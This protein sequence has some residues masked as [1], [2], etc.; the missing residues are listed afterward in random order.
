MQSSS[1]LVRTVIVLVLGVCWPTQSLR[2]DGCIFGKGG[3]Y[4]PEKEQRAFIEWNDGQERLFV[5][6]R[7]EKTA[8]PTV[9]IVPVPA[10]PKAVKAEPVEKFPHVFATKSA[11]KGAQDNLAAAVVLTFCANSGSLIAVLPWDTHASSQYKTAV[12]VGSVKVHQHVE[13]LGMI[14]E[15]ITA[16][17]SDALDA[18]LANKKMGIRSTDIKALEPYMKEKYTLICGWA[19]DGKD[20]MSARALR[21][22]FPCPSVFFPLR[23]TRVYEGDIDTTFFVRGWFK[24]TAG[25]Q[26][27]DLKCSYM[28]GRVSDIALDVI[29]EKGEPL[30]PK[31]REI[32]DSLGLEPVTQVRLS[33]SPRNWTHDLTMDSGTPLAID[34]ALTIQNRPL[35]LWL[36][37]I[38][39]SLALS[40]LLPFAVIPTGSRRWTDW[41][42]AAGTGMC[43]G[44]TIIVS[45]LVFYQW[46]RLRL[47]VARP[48]PLRGLVKGSLLTCAIALSFALLPRA[49]P[50]YRAPIILEAPAALC[51][52]VL[53]VAAPVATLAVLYSVA[54]K[55]AWWLL[56]FSF[57]H[58]ITATLVF[59][60]IFWWLGS[61]A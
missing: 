47:S 33:R 26:L 31:M 5:A 50:R 51:T 35:L 29:M 36:V 4:I 14:V 9:W 16:D 25:A 27:H 58:F 2:A 19:L 12:A 56:G 24:P 49:F 23:P 46:C 13:K 41:V 55:K 40:I 3:K 34:V 48:N 20:A 15:V 37:S 11:V 8:G 18:Y 60:G 17:S 43:L 21:I 45:A 38:L 53:V 22:D 54:G 61:Y 7:T 30:T 10:D 39:M 32:L 52:L 42:W 28:E 6:T 57:L 44:L 59:V 1:Q